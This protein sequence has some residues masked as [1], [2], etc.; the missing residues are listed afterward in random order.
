[1]E[2]RAGTAASRP[3]YTGTLER[4]QFQ[5]FTRRS[6]YLSVERPGNVVVS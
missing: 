3:L 4:G 5:R 1:M 2:V 6:L